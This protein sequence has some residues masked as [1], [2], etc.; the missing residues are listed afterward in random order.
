MMTVLMYSLLGLA[1][2][3]LLLSLIF[4]YL[5]QQYPR[6]P[7]SDLPDWGK[8]FDTRI[9]AVDGGFLEVWRIEP[10][11]LSKGTVILAHGWGRNR[12]RMVG[13]ARVFGRMGFTTVFH[14]ARDH[15]NS[16]PR[17]FMNAVKFCEDI[18]AVLDWVR[19]PVILYGH[20]AGA[21]G[22]ILAASRHPDK[23]QLLILE[24]CYAYT[25]EAL[26]NLYRWFNKL[27][28]TCFGPAIVF[29]MDVFYRSDIDQTSPA[30]IAPNVAMPVLVI[31]GENDLRFP[32]SYAHALR[33]S[34]KPGQAELYIAPGA[35][36]SD[37]SSTRGYPAAIDGFLERHFAVNGGAGGI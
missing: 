12:N 21:G 24:G 37:S 20:S 5:V 29:W 31:H 16:S 7:V 33:N 3:Y 17:R 11:G 28:G 6:S 4:T 25:K 36:H 32:V 23:V 18:E 27:F 2:A 26:I 10:D 35:G 19:T 30:L 1:G 14:S 34:F 13:R 8:V 22:S 9:P 15:G